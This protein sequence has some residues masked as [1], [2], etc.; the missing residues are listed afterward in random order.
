MLHNKSIVTKS[1]SVSHIC[2]PPTNQVF[3]RLHFFKVGRGDYINLVMMN[4]PLSIQKSEKVE[5]LL[6]EI[7]SVAIWT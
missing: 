3:P 5:G 1:I 4:Y 7:K 2:D 6:L